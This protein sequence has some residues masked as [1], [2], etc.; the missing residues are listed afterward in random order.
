M[1]YWYEI[2]YDGIQSDAPSLNEKKLA[3]EVF[4]VNLFDKKLHFW[5]DLAEI[6]QIWP[7]MGPELKNVNFFDFVNLLAINLL[8]QKSLF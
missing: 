6:Q 2:W 7:M 8:V 1:S 4:F 3:K 5:A